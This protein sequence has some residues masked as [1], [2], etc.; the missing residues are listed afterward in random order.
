MLDLGFKTFRVLRPP[1]G[2]FVVLVI[3]F[4]E[5]NSLT[6]APK[7]QHSIIPACRCETVPWYVVVSLFSAFSGI[8][9]FENTI[10][11]LIM[12]I[13]LGPQL[14]AARGLTQ[15][16]LSTGFNL[17][18]CRYWEKLPTHIAAILATN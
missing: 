12:N 13:V 7:G 16:Q 15:R 3:I 9:L 10:A 14:R 5:R 8:S 11:V 2:R 4:F 17:R 6:A 1:F 18:A